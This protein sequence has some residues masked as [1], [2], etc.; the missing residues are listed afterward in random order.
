MV[1]IL[2]LVGRG[3]WGSNLTKKFHGLGRCF[4]LFCGRFFEGVLKNRAFFGGNSLV[5]LW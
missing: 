5:K 2:L 4:W 1:L 3:L